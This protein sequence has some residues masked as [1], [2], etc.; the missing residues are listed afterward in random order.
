MQSLKVIVPKLFVVR[1]PFP[2]RSEPGGDES[3]VPFAAMSL[4]G[5]ESGIEQD[6]EVLRDGRA[7]HLEKARD[8]LDGAVGFDQEIE[9]PTPGRVA[10]RREDIR[11]AI[12][13]H[14]HAGSIRKTT[15]TCQDLL[16][17]ID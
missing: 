8:R 13:S 17:G 4:L 10:D 2:D 6:A 15:L 9:H 5:H 1:N 16:I 12:G 3:I 14:Y 11:P 7:T